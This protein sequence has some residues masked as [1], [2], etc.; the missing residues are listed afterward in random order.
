MGQE[1]TRVDDDSRPLD[2]TASD[3][4]T[5]DDPDAIEQDIEQTRAEMS[6]TID[7]IQERLNPEALK[8]QAK[9]AAHDATI[10]RVIDAKD[11]AV[12]KVQDL[13]QQ[14]T[15]KVREMTGGNGGHQYGGQSGTSHLTS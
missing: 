8:A 6:G 4:T 3:M 12:E 10:G 2:A 15:D 1:T 5:S 7:A 9:E 14:A 13:T 11:Q